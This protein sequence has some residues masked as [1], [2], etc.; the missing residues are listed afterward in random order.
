MIPNGKKIYLCN[1]S[2]EIITEINGL[3][4]DSVQYSIHT[5]DY[6]SLSFNVNRYIVVDGVELESLGYEKF[7][8][9]MY[10]LLEDIGYFQMQEPEKHNDGEK[11]YKTI[12]AYSCEKE[13]EDKDLPELK[14]NTGED[15]SLERLNPDNIDELGIAKNYVTF[16]RSGSSG[17]TD[18][19]LLHY[20]VDRMP[21]WT[22]R[23][24]DV[25][26]SLWYKKATF[27]E[28]S[29]N[30]YAALTSLIAPKFECLITFDI[31]NKRVGAISKDHLESKTVIVEKPDGTIETVSYSNDFDTN[32][33]IGFRNLAN[34]IDITTNEDS[35]YTQFNCAGNENLT[36]EDVNF[37]QSTV[38]DL[39]Y[40]M[41]EPYMSE[42]TAAKIQSWVDWCD[43]NRDAYI[44]YSKQFAD[45]TEKKT[46]LE[47]RLPNDADYWNQWDEM[48]EEL[49]NKNLSY[50]N[51]L[52]ESLQISVDERPDDQKYSIINDEKVYN[53]VLKPDGTIN[54]DYYLP[55]LKVQSNGYG[56][57]YTYF[58]I[59]TYI[60]PNIQT[61]IDNLSLV[62][63]SKKDYITDYETNWE[64]YGITE[65]QNK[66]TVYLEVIDLKKDFK[67][68]WEG[69]VTDPGYEDY[70]SNYDQYWNAYK[71]LYGEHGIESDP[72][73]GTL[74]YQLNILL[75][76]QSELESLLTDIQNRRA[77]MKNAY[78]FRYQ[79]DVGEYIYNY[80]L[81][82]KEYILIQ[83]LIHSTDYS[84][85]NIFT[86][87]LD[88]T[89]TK[90]DAEKS[91]FDDSRDKIS[92]VS[93]PQ[94]NFSVTLD[95]LMNIPEFSG[96]VED[97]TLLRFIRL[98]V[99]DDY[100]VKVRIVGISYNPCERDENLTLEFSNMITSK[101]GRSDLTDL[102]NSEN[103]RG[104][105]NS[106]SLGANTDYDIEFATTLL[107]TMIKTNLFKNSVNQTVDNLTVNEEQVNRLISN[108]IES[109]EI[110]VGKITGDEAEFEMFF[111]KYSKLD[112]VVANVIKTVKIQPEQIVD[113]NGNTFADLV[114]GI[115]NIDTVTTNVITALDGSDAFLKLVDGVVETGSLAADYGKFKEAFITVSGSDNSYIFNLTADNATIN[116]EAVRKLIAEQLMVSDLKAGDITIS[117]AMRILSENGMMVMNGSAL[118][119]SG[120]LKNSD[121]NPILDD[122]GNEQTYV[123]I[124]LGYDTSGE[125]SL[126]IRNSSGASIM[127]AEGITH[128]AI[129]DGLI[130]NDMIGQGTISKDKLSFEVET[131]VDENGREYM[132]TNI[133]NI[134]DGS[135]GSFGVEYTTF[136]K[137][138]TEKVE[139]VTPY[140]VE[141][142]SSNG[143]M[144]RRSKISTTL[145]CKV[146][147]GSEDI[148]D[149]FEASAFHWIKKDEDEVVD[150]DWCMLHDGVGNEITIS[151]SDIWIK[152]TFDCHVD[153]VTA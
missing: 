103:N 3:V 133:S 107:Q 53:P 146:Y 93:Q 147:K 6:Q 38:I 29:I 89:V 62:E 77:E 39:S 117:D 42:S 30:L 108:Y 91:L 110:S 136:K 99:R 86:T 82:E 151:K 130:V 100:S 131:Q 80:D 102:L 74:Q 137:N 134:L 143:N 12:T 48:D 68:P 59:I 105:K 129:A 19:S 27:D 50:Y 65:L 79:N 142:I 1:P 115:I 51:A 20:I 9:Y 7:G 127:T 119:I 73:E 63:D 95:N 140:S 33:F 41:A 56:G 118:Q 145:T 149:Q 88:T 120:I 70:K 23:D 109:A 2:Y 84:N 43:S 35:V 8:V 138:I 152:A 5:K 58:E 24:E 114:N 125:P 148:T 83:T 32:I 122:E 112:E 116:E 144:F 36:F 18:Y 78:L 76:E 57:Y 90:I 67:L 10:L 111:S 72:E 98:G 61:A 69:E 25:D 150:E 113:T 37:G 126:I 45:T 22:I 4:T 52:L 13:F 121:G 11:E 15:G 47:D 55:L 106:I 92:E 34:S 97:C 49:L 21:G 71:Y 64:L 66:K 96:W 44:N 104:S 132:V 75:A 139:E 81:T 31:L 141:I 135:G 46:E 60:I 85:S 153:G 16:Y 14:V 101:S 123:G 87:S 128:E 17:L 94:F 26:R 54:H 124:Q 28:G 40:F